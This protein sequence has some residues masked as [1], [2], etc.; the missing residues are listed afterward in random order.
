M[1]DRLTSSNL[2]VN[3]NSLFKKIKKMGNPLRVKQ[4]YE[5]IQ[6]LIWL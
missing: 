5:V 6:K 1:N 4:I 3:G 2:V